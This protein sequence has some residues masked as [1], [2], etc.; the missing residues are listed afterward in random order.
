MEEQKDGDQG[1]RGAEAAKDA[2]ADDVDANAKQDVGVGATTAVVVD[3]PT[4]DPAVEVVD[5]AADG[6]GGQE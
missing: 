1:A 5:G 4:V 2:K 3:V 6:E